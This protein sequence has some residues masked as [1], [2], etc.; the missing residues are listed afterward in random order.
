MHIQYNLEKCATRATDATLLGRLRQRRN[1]KS[2]AIQG[3]CAFRPSTEP[4]VVEELSRHSVAPL[5]NDQPAA[6]E[7]PSDQPEAQTHADAAKKPAPFRAEDL[8]GNEPCPYSAKQ[9]AAF[10]VSH[11]RL[12]C[13]P[14]TKNPWDWR[15]REVC[16]TRCKTPCDLQHEAAKPEGL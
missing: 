8:A 7:N 16:A 5:T 14:A 13:C 2:S 1:G 4:E 9:L 10:L 12:V 11:P 15:Y 6:R 3:S